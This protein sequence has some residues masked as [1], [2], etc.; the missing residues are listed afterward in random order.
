MKGK[1]LQ[2]RSS[3]FCDISR[4]KH[5]NINISH[6]R[7]LRVNRKSRTL[8]RLLMGVFF[9]YFPILEGIALFLLQN[10]CNREFNCLATLLRITVVELSI[11]SEQHV[12]KH[13]R[14]QV[15]KTLL[16]SCI[17]TARKRS[18]RRLCFYRCLS[19][20]RGGSCLSACWETPPARETPLP[21]RPPCQWDPPARE[22][23]L[24]MRPP[25]QG[26]PPGPDPRGKLR[27]T[28]SRPTPKG[29]NWVGSDPG[30][31][32]RGIRSR[33]TPKGKIEGI[34]S[35]PTPKGEIQGD[36]VQANIQGG[37]SGGSGP[38]P[39]PPRWLLLWVVRILLECILVP[40][41]L[42]ILVT[43]L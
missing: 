37:N 43:L 32:P 11:W 22:T 31:H 2:K 38:N 27:G 3:D 13:D 42:H 25:C 36:Q 29:E 14:L 30:P 10:R 39:P 6:R 26:D 4:I 34:R 1:R 12:N 7:M 24:P 23:P 33:P 15:W 40:V 17:F 28:R 16:Q 18:L 20:H 8:A 5:K 35:R 21:R 9:L 19:V 41:L